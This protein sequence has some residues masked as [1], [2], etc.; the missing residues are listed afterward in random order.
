MASFA[1]TARFIGISAVPFQWDWGR[2]FFQY[3]WREPQQGVP[4]I[5][6]WICCRARMP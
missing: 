2:H 1:A 3:A 4:C 6:A 5:P